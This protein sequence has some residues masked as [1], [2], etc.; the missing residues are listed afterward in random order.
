MKKEIW[1]RREKRKK[2][3]VS[4]NKFGKMRLDNMKKKIE[5]KEKKGEI[6]WRKNVNECIKVKKRNK[7]KRI[8]IGERWKIKEELRKEMNVEKDNG[9]F[10]RKKYRLK[11]GRED[12]WKKIELIRRWILGLRREGMNVNKMINRGKRRRL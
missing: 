8:R 10:L 1:E 6:K 2:N 9:S 11:L 7:R 12:V 4:K 5:K 3:S